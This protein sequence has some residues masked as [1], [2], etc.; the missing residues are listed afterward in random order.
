MHKNYKKKG[1]GKKNRSRVINKQVK[2][3]KLL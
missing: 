2:E 1:D 3:K